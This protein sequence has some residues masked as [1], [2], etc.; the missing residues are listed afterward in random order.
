MHPN[1]HI[2][3]RFI[4]ATNTT[5]F[6]HL[7]HRIVLCTLCY[8]PGEYDAPTPDAETQPPKQQQAS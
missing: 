4:M 7:D 6:A 3:Q 2:D 8:N 1:L 5:I